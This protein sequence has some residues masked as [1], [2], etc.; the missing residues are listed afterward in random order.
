MRGN[1]T[2]QCAGDF[3]CAH[4]ALKAHEYE[5]AGEKLNQILQYDPD[6]DLKSD[7]DWDLSHENQWPKAELLAAL[8]RLDIKNN[9]SLPGDESRS[10]ATVSTAK[11]ALVA[12]NQAQNQQKPG[13]W[14]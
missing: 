1:K 5:L 8:N 11:A 6:A 2:W 14:R 10:A 13:F 9:P 4:L 7:F 3:L 12:I